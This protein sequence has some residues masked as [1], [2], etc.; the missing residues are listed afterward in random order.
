MQN[1]ITI[2]NNAD[3]GE[4]RT[5][6]LDGNPWFVGKDVA[7]A[8]GY[9]NQN[10]DIVRHVDEDDRLMLDGETQYQN[11]IELSYKDLGQRGGWIINESGLYA[12]IFGSRLESAREFKRWV[13][14]EVLPSI[15]KTGKYSISPQE[16]E[17][18]KHMEKIMKCGTYAEWSNEISKVLKSMQVKFGLANTGVALR[19]IYAIF[20]DAHNFTIDDVKNERICR[21]ITK[22]DRVKAEVI[23]EM[24][25]LQYIYTEK[26]MRKAIETIVQNIITTYKLGLQLEDTVPLLNR[27][28]TP[29]LR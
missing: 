12:L 23:N 26:A 14:S 17:Y 2:F 29:F 28:K 18:K 1:E 11:G 5:L 7:T 19:R 20:N 15:R 4:I 21:L 22:G 3:F 16:N 13:T 27:Y 10:R 6:T 24:S 8:L 25:T 9:E